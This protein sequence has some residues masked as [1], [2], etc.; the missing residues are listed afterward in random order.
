MLRGWRRRVL[1]PLAAVAAL[2]V[3][4]CTVQTSGEGVRASAPS[5]AAPTASATPSPTPT[6][7][8]S[9][10]F[11]DCTKLVDPESAGVPSSRAANLVISCGKLAV[12]RDY[13]K[14]TA[15]DLDLYVL[16]IHDDA[17][18]GQKPMIV[19]P[20]GPGGSSVSLAISLAGA[21]S[22]DVLS[23][24]DIVGVDPRGVGL[25][26]PI[27]CL[28]DAQKDSVFAAAPDVRTAAGISQAKTLAAAW[29][30]GCQAAT[31][32]DG[33]ALGDYNTVYAA[34]DMDQVRTALGADAL[35]YLGFSYGTLLGSVYATQFPETVGRMVLDG[36]VD[37]SVNFQ[38]S[39]ETQLKGFEEAFG[40][41][42]ADCRTKSACAAMG[43]PATAVTALAR[44]AAT[45]G[46]IPVTAAGEKRKATVGVVYSAVAE[47][48][49]DQGSWDALGRAIVS[50]QNGNGQGL[51]DLA[52]QYYQR[53]SQGHYTN[54][55]DAFTLVTCNDGGTTYTDAQLAAVGKD[56]ATRY[57]VFGSYFAGQLAICNGWPASGHAVPTAVPARGSAPI[58]VI[59]TLN[60]PAT[61]YVNTAR[62]ASSLGVGVVL[63]WQGQGHTAYLKSRCI[64]TAVDTYL[65]EGTVPAKGATCP[66]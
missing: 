11:T 15:G 23:T 3:A 49:Y 46:G 62:L 4:G 2:T 14:P 17:S 28:T 35:D 37:P 31:K 36:A 33:S 43:D 40:Q 66:A 9:I 56:W 6:D 16:K 51:L 41:F 44:R 58:V 26:S 34:R 48:L 8:A 12:P 30:R 32:A 1:L 60:D 54:L 19:N 20:G 47:A 65:V 25:S 24:Y 45:G 21:V 27:T 55:F 22:D 5:T 10:D 18:T 53:D 57:P 38:Q 50:G 42:A 61:P 29:V 13:S 52:D 7:V 39:S 63:T 64:D 59:G